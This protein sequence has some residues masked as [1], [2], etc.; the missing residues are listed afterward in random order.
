MT[1]MGKTVII[2]LDGVP[3][4]MIEDFAQSGV[5]P[6]MAELINHG[7]FKKM[8]SST[9]EISSVAWSSVYHLSFM[10]AVE[11]QKVVYHLATTVTKAIL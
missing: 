2:G 10:K 6:N 4:G 11:G 5:I 3:Y 8:L 1:K 9:P 7:I